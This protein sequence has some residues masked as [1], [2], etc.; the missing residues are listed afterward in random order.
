LQAAADAAAIS[1]AYEA[2]AGDAADISAAATVDAGRNGFTVGDN[3][4]TIAV[5]NPPISG[6]YAGDDTAVEVIVSQPQTLLFS[7]L[8]LNSATISARAVARNGGGSGAGTY[9]VLALDATASQAAYLAN[10]AR[11]PNEDCG[12]AVNS[13]SATGL[14]LKNNAI[15]DGPV[16]VA[17]GYHT[18]NNAHLYGSVSTGSVTAD[19]YADVTRESLGSCTTGQ[20]VSASNN[21]TVNLVPGR[22][23][24][25]LSFKNN[26]VVNF[27]PGTYYIESKFVFQNNA[28]MNATG[29]VTLVMVGNYAID[30]GNNAKLNLTAPTSGTYAGLA[31]FGD[32]TGTSTVTQTF[33]NNTTLNV[34]GAIY[35]P[36]QIVLLENNATS[37]ADGCTQLIA[38]K[39]SFSNNA[40]LPSNCTGAGTTPIGAA[41]KISL[42][43]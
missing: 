41:A 36:N 30:V 25:G 39:V 14:Y 12:I 13:T 17:G 29:G 19:P 26:A 10:N 5:Y 40:N 31:M 15:V 42:V 6:T 37:D 1:A 23:C 16:S 33:D 8:M 34:K 7:K 27:S 4:A 35:F 43:E 2:V 3:G 20:T 9:C 38:R 24:S 18:S 11:L 32:R 21:V 28:V 22:F